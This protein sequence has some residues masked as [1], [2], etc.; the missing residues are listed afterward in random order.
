MK[1][2]MFKPYLIPKIISGDKTHARQLLKP[3]PIES[4]AELKEHSGVKGYWIPYAA[5]RRMVNNNVGSRKNDCGYTPRY[6]VGETVYIK[7]AW[8]EDY[9][10]E[11]IYYKL[12]GGES[13]GPKGFWRSP[14]F[15]PA[16]AARTF[17]KILSVE[18]KRLQDMTEADA[19]AEG[20]FSVHLPLCGFDGTTVWTWKQYPNQSIYD[21]PIGA[22]AHLWG[23]INPDSPWACNPWVF[24]YGLEVEEC[25]S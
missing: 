21:S 20:I 9:T 22:F 15:M 5:D 2:I 12:D 16:W 19:R 4:V 13:P 11:K 25:T 1:G 3:Q 6:R 17:S 7:E 10:G 8:C 18:A 24:D 23:S 14:L